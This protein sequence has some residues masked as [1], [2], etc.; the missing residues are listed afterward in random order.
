MRKGEFYDMSFNFELLKETRQNNSMKR[1]ELA[2]LLGVSESHIYKLERGLKQPSLKLVRKISAVIGIPSDTLLSGENAGN[3]GSETSAKLVSHVM[4][5]MKDRLEQECRVRKKAEKLVLEKDRIIECL[6]NVIKLQT[7][8]ADIICDQ[9]SSKDEK[10]KKLKELAKD[11]VKGGKVRFGEIC[12]AL[13]IGRATL[14]N[15]LWGEKRAFSCEF[16]EGGQIMATNPDEARLRLCCFDCAAFDSGKCSGHGK[17]TRPEN[18]IDLIE[19]LEV[20]GVTRRIEQSKILDASY[21]RTLSSHEISE[22][23]YRYRHGLHIPEGLY[24]LEMRKQVR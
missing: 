18:I 14:R 20:N 8:F 10:L 5:G 3:D 6:E 19:R 2:K 12:S 21:G 1:I 13:R 7:K 22:V 15:W 24:Y 4:T 11:T 16:V 17:E 9:H 23:I